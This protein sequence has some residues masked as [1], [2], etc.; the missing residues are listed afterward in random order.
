MRSLWSL[1]VATRAQLGDE[2]GIVGDEVVFGQG[3][4][5]RGQMSRRNLPLDPAASDAQ[6]TG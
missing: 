4:L 2:G 6:Q 3:M 5:A 1:R